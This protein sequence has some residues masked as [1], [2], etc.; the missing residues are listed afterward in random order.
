MQINP[1]K[2]TGMLVGLLS[3]GLLAGSLYF[4]YTV[5][6]S[7]PSSNPVAPL[8][9]TDI[10]ALGP[11]AQKAGNILVDPKQKISV[12]KKDLS[13]TESDLFKSFTEPPEV[14][15][16]SDSRGRPDPFAPY[17]AP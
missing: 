1:S 5:M 10:G 2:F 15:P 17:V 12:S 14:V 3:L 6:F 16:M 11:K 8:T 13:F 4:M 7:G 9:A